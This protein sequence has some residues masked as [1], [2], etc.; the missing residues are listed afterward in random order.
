MPPSSKT[1]SHR[2][3]RQIFHTI[4][5]NLAQINL[6]FRFTEPVDYS[7]PN[8]GPDSHY[9]WTSFR[10]ERHRHDIDTVLVLRVF[11]E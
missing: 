11:Q 2:T 8:M 1:L 6:V 9:P 7:L 3:R 10:G 5:K 4:R